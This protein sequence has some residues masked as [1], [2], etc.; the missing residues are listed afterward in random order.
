MDKKYIDDKV[1]YIENILSEQDLSILDVYCREQE[2]WVS[3]NIGSNHWENNV[4]S[5]IDATNQV[6][7]K[8]IDIIEKYIDNDEYR[9]SIN[10]NLSRFTYKENEELAMVY[11]HDNTDPHTKCGLVFYINDDYEGGEI[12]YINKDIL[13]KPIKNSIIVHPSDEDYTHGVKSV[14]SGERYMIT[15]F[16]YDYAWWNSKGIFK[17]ND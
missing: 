5:G 9:V 12:H 14:K 7:D 13:F 11:H 17:N 2:S 15:M 16:G 6:V 8:L 10:K 4:K 3:K 1:F